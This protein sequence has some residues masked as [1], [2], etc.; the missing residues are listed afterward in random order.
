MSFVSFAF[1][2][3][4]AVVIAARLIV[5][6]DKCE[7]SYLGVLLVASLLFYGWHT[8]VYLALILS[9]TA[10]DYVAGRRLERPGSLVQRRLVLGIS[11][12]VN[13]GLLFWFKYA[14]FFVASLSSALAAAGADIAL[15]TEIVS[16]ELPVGISFYTFQSMSYTI[17]VYFGRM[18]A[19]RS[20]LRFLLFV[21]FFPQLVAGPIVR[22]RDF[23]RQL[24]RKRRVR[25]RAMLGGAYLIVRGFFLKMAVADNLSY[26]VDDLWSQATTPGA[27]GALCLWVAL[28]FSGQIFAD[29]AG[30]SSIARGLGL[31]L[32]FRLP[33]NF[34]A[35]YLAA[36]FSE[37]WRRWHITLSTWLRDYLY[38]PLGGNKGG[39][40]RT[41]L[42]LLLVMLLGGL[43]H[44]A[45]TTFVIW[46][47]LHGLFLA[48]ERLLRL[49]DPL[50][51]GSRFLRLVWFLVVQAGVLVGWV[52][53]RADTAADAVVI[54]GNLSTFGPVPWH[55]V[56]ASAAF[57]LPIIVLHL[58]TYFAERHHLVLSNLEKAAVAGAMAAM[59]LVAYGDQRGFI[60]FQF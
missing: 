33:V 8:P 4:Y 12:A 22:A 59:T 45:A 27:S 16:S 23:F 38:F 35:P 5:G 11:V 31:T 52:F 13:L 56:A 6:R 58:R 37:F 14:N 3:L 50:A 43:W 40:G 19:Q 44:G 41:Y 1:V 54:L 17:D 26:F 25:A 48:V 9:S 29:F 55:I 39:M 49:N 57:V 53:F 51:V 21:S 60:Y 28:L 30:Y 34:R 18:A 46:G 42:N 2:A 10:V 24:P 20:F 15:P 36:S 47:G 32:G 7:R